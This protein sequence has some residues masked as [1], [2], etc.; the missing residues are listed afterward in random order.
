MN[1]CATKNYVGQTSRYIATAKHEIRNVRGFK[2]EY[3][4][5]IVLCGIF[6]FTGY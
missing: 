2:F 4:Y 1:V 6:I 5:S 3:K